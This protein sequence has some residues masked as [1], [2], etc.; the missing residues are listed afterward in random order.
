MKGSG[1]P[2]V[3]RL[4]P[5]F[6]RLMLNLFLP[7]EHGKNVLIDRI[8]CRGRSEVNISSDQPGL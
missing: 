7:Q 3:D 4:L 2:L 6:R 5:I 8:I 1:A